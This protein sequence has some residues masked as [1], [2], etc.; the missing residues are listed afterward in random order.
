MD[1]FRPGF[2]GPLCQRFLETPVG[3]NPS[4]QDDF[5]QACSPDGFLAPF[6][7]YIHDG[8]LEGGRCIFSTETV[9]PLF[10]CMEVIDDGTFQ[11][12]EAEIKTAG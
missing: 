10:F 5:L 2:P 3:R 7:Q 4:G 8:L 6:H 12:A 11:A 1:Q 9:F